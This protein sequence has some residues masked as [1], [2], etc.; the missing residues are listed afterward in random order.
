MP[1]SLTAWW[2][3]RD[4]TWACLTWPFKFTLT[5]NWQA[6]QQ[7]CFSLIQQNPGRCDSI[8]LPVKQTYCIINI[9]HDCDYIM[10]FTVYIYIYIWY[11]STI[12]FNIICGRNKKPTSLK[13][14]AFLF[15]QANITKILPNNPSMACEITI[16]LGSLHPYI[17]VDHRNIHIP[18]IEGT[19]Q[20]LK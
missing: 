11:V 4:H 3:R 13:N 7:I 1:L 20:R 14:T 16:L 5:S 17:Q 18:S 10:I 15:T 9:V 19:S 12:L 8:Q 2:T 6:A